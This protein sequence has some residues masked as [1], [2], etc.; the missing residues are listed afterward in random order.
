MFLLSEEM[1]SMPFADVWEEYCRRAGVPLG[2]E[3]YSEVE[4]YE[5]EVL[6]KR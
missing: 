2:M 6:S 4:K 5:A 1:K 3:W